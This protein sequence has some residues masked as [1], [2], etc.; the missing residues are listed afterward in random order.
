MKS[1]LHQRSLKAELE[2]FDRLLFR[3]AY[4]SGKYEYRDTRRAL[5]RLV[6]VIADQ[7]SSGDYRAIRVFSG[8]G[9]PGS[10]LTAA[11]SFS[12]TKWL[13][14]T[15][16]DETT[17]H[18]SN[19]DA[20]STR[21]LFREILPRTEYESIFSGEMKLAGRIKKLK[22]KNRGSGLSWLI[23]RMDESTLQERDKES[24]FHHL[25]VFIRWKSSYSSLNRISAR[26]PSE[27]IYYHKKIEHKPVLKRILGKALP[28]PE[29]LNNHEATHLINIARCTL[30][31]LYRETEPVTYADSK[32]VTLF[33]LERGLS[34][35]LYGMNPERRLS[36]ESY[37]GYMAFK[38]GVPVAYGGGWLFGHRCQFGINILPAYRGGESAFIFCQLL[39]VYHQYYKASLFVVKPYQ[40]GRH[41]AEAIRSGAFWF[42]YKAGFRPEKND[43]LQ[44]AKEEWRKKNSTPAYRSPP[45]V[46]KKLTGSDLLLAL[47][48]MAF[49]GYDPALLSTRITGFINDRFSG[50]RKTA[51]NICL[52]ELK[53]QAGINRTAGWT[54]CERRALAEWSL[55]A[56][57]HLQI[58]KWSVAEKKQFI[59]LVRLKGQA[60]E[61]NFILHL[62]QCRRF[63]KDLN[64]SVTGNN[65]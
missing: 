17:L 60:G 8:S 49:P 11:F 38:N 46:L 1:K 44:A 47:N 10:E 19:A 65:K 34:I 12:L 51:T 18:S 9:L 48:K 45:A 25:K 59:R 30:A 32:E 20:E 40:F 39:R 2:Y 6:T 64:R 33:R 63:W 58:S 35:A 22:G 14:T 29:T 24:A 7:L 26:I 50:S 21:M 61:R 23:Q 57:S 36:L 15:F 53:K 43:L 31:Y 54:P 27:A 5:N 13:T 56:A 55:L 41:N 62:Q 42:Y 52:K 3:L 16:P 37:M 4:P 28:L